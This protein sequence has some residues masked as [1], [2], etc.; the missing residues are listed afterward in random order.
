MSLRSSDDTHSDR[1]NL[2]NGVFERHIER[3]FAHVYERERERSSREVELQ[4]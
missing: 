4:L 2:G 3:R 1:L